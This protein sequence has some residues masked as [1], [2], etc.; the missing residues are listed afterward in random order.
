MIW[1]E[2][3][4]ESTSHLDSLE[5]SKLVI[6]MYVTLYGEFDTILSFKDLE[7][8]YAEAFGMNQPR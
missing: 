3:Y 6:I 1:E 4:Y 5:S 7:L 8:V 2:V